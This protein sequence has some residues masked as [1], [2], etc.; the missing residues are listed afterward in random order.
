MAGEEVGDSNRISTTAIP[1]LEKRR[2]NNIRKMSLYRHKDKSTNW[3]THELE[4]KEQFTKRRY[5]YF[6]LS[7]LVGVSTSAVTV[8]PADW[9]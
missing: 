5:P 7:I 8:T 2:S 9:I 6:S 1:T 3:I 4:L